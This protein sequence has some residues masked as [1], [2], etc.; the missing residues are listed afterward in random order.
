MKTFH[1]YEIRNETL[2]ETYVSRS[3]LR[4][5]EFRAGVERVP[6]PVIAHWDWAEQKIH[7]ADV[8]LALPEDAARS[9]LEE[10]L[11]TFTPRPGWKMLSDA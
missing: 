1:V 11:R 2:K 5:D 4:G 8:E 7:F 6:P 9:F 3:S 10:Y